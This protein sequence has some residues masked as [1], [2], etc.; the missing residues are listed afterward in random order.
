MKSILLIQSCRGCERLINY[1]LKLHSFSRELFLVR[2][3]YNIIAEIEYEDYES[4][5]KLV[6][7]LCRLHEIFKIE[8]LNVKSI[9]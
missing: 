3:E 9:F 6:S 1:Y 4:F 7:E 8:I 2:G 5:K